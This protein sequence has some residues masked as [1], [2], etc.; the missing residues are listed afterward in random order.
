[1]TLAVDPTLDISPAE[2][3]RGKDKFAAWH[4]SLP[5]TNVV[6]W[7]DRDMPKML[8]E[9]GK[10][11]RLHVRAPRAAGEVR[12]PRRERD[13]MIQFSRRVSAN[14]HIAYDPN[15]EN[16]RLYL[17]VNPEVQPTIRERFWVENNLR[18][19]NLNE[20]AVIAG[21]RHGVRDY[22]NVMVKPIG[23]LT[24]VV[25][26]TA[27]A[28]DQDAA[29]VGSFYIHVMGEVDGSHPVL[30]VDNQ[31]RFWLAGGGYR[32]PDPGITG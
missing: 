11:I 30:S 9:C 28:G 24:G 14:S 7:N 12:H 4:W 27:K 20:L 31:G 8:I 29:G 25:Y 22:P 13:T 23:V 16:E 10:L 32:T 5:A 1:L 21:G 19:M 6:D 15:H 18:P 26:K 17:L 2:I 3:N